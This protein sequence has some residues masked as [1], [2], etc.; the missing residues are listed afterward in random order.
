[1]AALK[2]REI[3]E[4]WVADSNSIQTNSIDKSQT[5]REKKSGEKEVDDTSASVFK[6]I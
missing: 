2:H 1:M 5:E 6:N 3:V 4:Y